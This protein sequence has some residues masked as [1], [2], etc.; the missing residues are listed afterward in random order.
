MAA[1]ATRG[2]L[3]RLV[4]L[5]VLGLVA[6]LL[7]GVALATQLPAPSGAGSA[8]DL[9]R[10]TRQDIP[11]PEG[12]TIN[13]AIDAIQLSVAKLDAAGAIAAAR[14]AHPGLVGAKPIVRALVVDGRPSW[15]VVSNDVQVPISG[16]VGLDIS[17]LHIVAI[18]GW[19]FVGLDGE[20]YDAAAVHYEA[21]NQPPP[22]LPTE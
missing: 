9:D 19:V 14:Q 11:M 2:I 7:V 18:Y 16:P 8:S 17:K 1:S 22:P 4:L 20:D 3:G 13:G 21:G 5:V 12:S 10:L 6:F 15:V